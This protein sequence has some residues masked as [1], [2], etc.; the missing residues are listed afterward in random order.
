[1]ALEN[2]NAIGA[3]FKLTAGVSPSVVG[4]GVGAVTRNGAGDYSIRLN[5][6]LDPDS[7]V[8]LATAN[9]ATYGA[10][11]LAIAAGG[12]SIN[13]KVFDAAGAAADVDVDAALLSLK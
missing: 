10:V 4:S 12:A 11:S 7:T 2:P 13:V 1:M 5:P 3:A 6:T 8:C 9:G